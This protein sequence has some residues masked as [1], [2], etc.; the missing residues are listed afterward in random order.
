MAA[1]TV[2]LA[3]IYKLLEFLPKLGP[4]IT[5]SIGLPLE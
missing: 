1:P 4:L 2:P 5:K 3:N